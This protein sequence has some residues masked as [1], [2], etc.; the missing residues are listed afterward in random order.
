MIAY[1]REWLD[2]LRTKETAHR[3]YADG[4]LSEAEWKTVEAASVSNFYSPNVFVR[5]GLAIFCLIL[6]LAAMGLVGMVVE[7]SS[8][9]GFS[10]FCILWGLIWL[11]VLEVRIIP[12]RH[13]G[14]GID[15]MLLYV[16]IGTL[17]SGILMFLPYSTPALAFYLLSWPFLVLGSIRY[18]DRFM[19]LAAFICSLGIVLLV[20]KDIPALAVLLL[21]FSGMAFS[22][23]VYFFAKRGQNR[24]SWRFWHAQLAILEMLALATFYA[25][26]NYFVVQQAGSDFFQLEQ[27]PLAWFF[28]LFTFL[29]PA[30]YIFWGLKIKDRLLLDIGIGSIA[31][32]VF[33]FR[34]YYHV[35]PWAWAAVIGGVVLFVTAYFSI[36]Y[37]HRHE[38]AFTYETD[39][40]TSL[41][42]EIEHQLIEQTI[43]NQPGPAPE[44]KDGFGGGEFG[45]SGGGG[46]F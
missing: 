14:S 42:Q 4:Q 12:G 30:G 37:L 19:T 31:V 23:G 2:A 22:A 13:L 17:L 10:L 45:G 39:G 7:P 25:S 33:T 40:E 11:A 16:G 41:L 32:A 46:E 27:V 21:P 35:M 29:V 36:R 1:N 8:E 26:G 5:I 3:W 20:V 18:G 24:Y 15:D 43:A 28:W 44:K 38:G 6:L 34:F 9:S